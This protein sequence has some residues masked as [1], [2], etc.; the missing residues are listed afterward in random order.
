MPC[1]S[2]FLDAVFCAAVLSFVVMLVG[3]S[4]VIVEGA[5]VAARYLLYEF[6]SV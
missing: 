4:V 5:F 6:N 2:G 1:V 3:W